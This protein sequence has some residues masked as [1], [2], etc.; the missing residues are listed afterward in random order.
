MHEKRQHPRHASLERCSVEHYLQKKEFSFNSRIINYSE[1]GL[2]LESDYSLPEWAPVRIN[3]DHGSDVQEEVGDGTLV[4]VVR[5]C[6]EQE[7]SYSGFY[8]IGVA[9]TKQT[10]H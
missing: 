6:A 3:L 7:G 2:M 9:F 10:A 1:G 5:W 4:G 8:G